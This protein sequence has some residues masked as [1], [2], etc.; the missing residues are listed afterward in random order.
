MA[1]KMK[2]MAT[3]EL[4]QDLEQCSTIAVVGATIAVAILEQL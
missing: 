1:K 3:K 4:K 2:N